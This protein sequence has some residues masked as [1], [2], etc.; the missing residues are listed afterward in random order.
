MLY[1][2]NYDTD[3]CNPGGLSVYNGDLYGVVL[4][5]REMECG[6]SPLASIA[7]ASAGRVARPNWLGKKSP[8]S[9]L[10]GAFQR[11]AAQGI[12]GSNALRE[13]DLGAGPVQLP[14]SA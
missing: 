6:R 2:F 4:V 8:E 12:G 14:V 10:R 3:G 9:R 1:R 13:V 11:D 7:R 5:Q